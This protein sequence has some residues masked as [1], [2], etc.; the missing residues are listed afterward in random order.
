MDGV[1]RIEVSVELVFAKITT[2]GTADDVW[3]MV[4]SKPLDLCDDAEIPIET[5]SLLCVARLLDKA[6]VE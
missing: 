3:M 6:P 4:V 2:F 5:D 1:T